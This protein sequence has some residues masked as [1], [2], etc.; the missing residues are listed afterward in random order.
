MSEFD[1]REIFE[2]YYNTMRLLADKFLEEKD[3]EK[4]EKIFEIMIEVDGCYK[5][6]LSYRGS[7]DC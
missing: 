1:L 4:A 7:R 3:D 2:K 6:L 5:R